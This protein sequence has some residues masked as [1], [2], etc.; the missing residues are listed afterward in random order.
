MEEKICG[1]CKKILPI[2]NFW[3]DPF[4][5]TGFCRCC[6]NCEKLR[7]RGK[8]RKYYPEIE[9]RRNKNPIRHR[10]HLANGA[11]RYHLKVGHISQSVCFCG[12]KDVVAHHKNGYDKPNYLVIEWMCKLHH[13]QKH[14]MMLE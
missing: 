14:G 5:K 12:E 9:K 8:K 2:L 1:C 13:F 6:K 4:R 11:V 10:R 3:K 7:R